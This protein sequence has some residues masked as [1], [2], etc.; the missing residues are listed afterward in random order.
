MR[1]EVYVAATSDHLHPAGQEDQ[2]KARP[3]GQLCLAQGRRSDAPFFFLAP[4]PHEREST[5]SISA[6][7]NVGTRFIAPGKSTN[8]LAMPG[9]PCPDY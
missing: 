4:A 5:N 1:R 2:E 9:P 6:P 8:K 7:Q 3:G